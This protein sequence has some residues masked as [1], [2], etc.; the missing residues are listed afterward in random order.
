MSDIEK[1]ARFEVWAT[2]RGLP[3]ERNRIGGDYLFDETY[4]AW[5]TW[6]AALTPP[7]G[8][9]LVPV[10]ATGPMKD[11]VESFVIPHCFLRTG[12]QIADFNERYRA[13]L[14]ARPEVQP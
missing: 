1:R 14:A 13:M 10:E 2:S 7:E 4:D 8:Y 12:V 9:V 11:A 6:Q 5:A 3:V